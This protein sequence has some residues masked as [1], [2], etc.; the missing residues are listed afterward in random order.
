MNEVCGTCRKI[1]VSAS[2]TLDNTDLM[3]RYNLSV[4]VLTCQ[5]IKIYKNTF[6]RKPRDT[7]ILLLLHSFFLDNLKRDLVFNVMIKICRCPPILLCKWLFLAAYH[8]AFFYPRSHFPPEE[9]YCFPSHAALRDCWCHY[10]L[11][12]VSEG[13]LE[14]GQHREY[15][16]TL[17]L[18][19]GDW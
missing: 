10:L 11:N 12:S 19:S 9:K 1:S 16:V 15:W 2:V 13:E 7:V 17:G 6:F 8:S 18:A 5:W 4:I 14:R 3:A